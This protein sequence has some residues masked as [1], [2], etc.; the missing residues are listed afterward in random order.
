[1][2]ERRDEREANALAKGRQFERARIGRQHPGVRNRF[3]PMPPLA[4]LEVVLN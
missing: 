3:E 1:M 4:S 2:L